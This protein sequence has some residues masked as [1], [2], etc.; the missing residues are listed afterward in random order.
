M[1]INTINV[2]KTEISKI[3]IKKA[4]RCLVDNGIEFDEA[5]TVLQALGHILL[6]TELEPILSDPDNDVCKTMRAT[7]TFISMTRELG[8][9]RR[10]KRPHCA[11]CE[12]MFKFDELKNIKTTLIAFA[13]KSS[14]FCYENYGIRPASDSY[15]DYV[16][17]LE[18]IGR[19]NRRSFNLN[20]FEYSILEE[21][22][23]YVVEFNNNGTK[24]YELREV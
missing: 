14:D 11:S 22:D 16:A 17:V 2:D 10:Q 19:N 20:D 24:N 15:E 7:E 3:D 23:V 13:I 8:E 9:S 12:E 21:C 6:N 18:K 1:E 4:E 5:P